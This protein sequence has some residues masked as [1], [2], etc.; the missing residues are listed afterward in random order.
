MFKKNGLKI[1]VFG[2]LA[3]LN[4]FF[5]SVLEYKVSVPVTM[6]IDQKTHMS[7]DSEDDIFHS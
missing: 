5:Y 7:E 4:M 3:L 2:A 6:T 1:F